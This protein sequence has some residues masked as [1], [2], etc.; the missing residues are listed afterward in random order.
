VLDFGVA[1]LEEGGE[2]LLPTFSREPL[3]PKD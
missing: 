3:D 1:D 2:V